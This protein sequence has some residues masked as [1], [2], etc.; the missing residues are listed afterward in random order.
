MTSLPHLHSL[1]VGPELQYLERLCVAS[2]KAAGHEFTIWSYEPETLKHVPDGIEVRDAADVMPRDRLICYRGSNSIALGANL[3]RI[4]LLDQGYDCWVDMD[5]IFLGPLD[6]GDDYIFACEHGNRM[7]NAIMMAPAGS[8]LVEDLKSLARP[9]RRPP[10]YGPKKSLRY[11]WKRLRNG[12]ME[13]EDY[14]WGTF[15]AGMLTYA[16]TKNGLERYAHPI[17]VLHPVSWADARKVYEPAEVVE[18]M[19]TDE[20]RTVHLWHSRLEGLRDAPPPKGSFIDK[21]CERFD[22]DPTY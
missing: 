4:E 6:F 3:W 10:W 9:N 16:I 13:L 19:L 11:Y 22:I 8:P 7:N 1:W 20:T 21:M 17:E 12:R 15:S 18:A 5:L 2:A 14:P